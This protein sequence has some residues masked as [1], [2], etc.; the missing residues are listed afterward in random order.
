M[1]A[2]FGLDDARSVLAPS[3]VFSSF[4]SPPSN[5]GVLRILDGRTCPEQQTLGDPADR[6]VYASNFAIGDLDGAADHRPE[7]VAASLSA[8]STAGGL[9]AFGVDP[10][11]P[12]LHRLRH[13]RRCHLADQPRH[14]PNDWHNNNG[15]PQHDL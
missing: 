12:T 1:V 4:A 8:P 14:M 2:D 3:I 7:I 11:T 6:L 5:G 13:G 9:V 15:P 10:T